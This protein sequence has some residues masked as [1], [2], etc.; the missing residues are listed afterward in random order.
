MGETY[1]GGC[2]CGAT[3]YVAIG[4][5]LNVRVCHCR[6]CQKALG[7]AFN[8]RALFHAEAVSLSG[9]ISRKN[10]SADLVR[11]F[12]TLCGST[13]FSERASLGALGMTLGSLDEPDRLPPAEHI[14]VSSKQAWVVLADGLPQHA[15]AAPA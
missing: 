11:G 5:P 12:C 1:Q 2:L 10:S 6:M 3:R 4:N 7:A 8:A 14:W 13:L 15:E 9:P